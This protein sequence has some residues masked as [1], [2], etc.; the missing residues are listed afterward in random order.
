MLFR[1]TALEPPFPNPMSKC[2]DISF[3]ITK[4]G[5]VDVSIFDMQGRRV[6][7]ALHEFRE[8]GSHASFWDGRNDDRMYLKNGV[9][10]IRLTGPDGRKAARKIVL[11]R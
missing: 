1:S 8:A 2:T 9:Y 10:F 4:G 3:T 11:A 5:V 7:T 6:R